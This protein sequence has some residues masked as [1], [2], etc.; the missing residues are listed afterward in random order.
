MS[1]EPIL[2]KVEEVLAAERK[3]FEGLNLDQQ[4]SDDYTALMVATLRNDLSA[5]E[6]LLRLGANPDLEEES[7]Q[8]ALMMAIEEHHYAV[9][10]TL[11]HYADINYENKFGDNALGHARFHRAEYIAD[12]LIHEGAEETGRPTKMERDNQALRQGYLDNTV[13]FASIFPYREAHPL[14]EKMAVLYPPHNCD[15]LR[16]ST[17]GGILFHIQK[18]MT[19][20]LR[21]EISAFQRDHSDA[22][23][24]KFGTS[25]DQ[26]SRLIQMA[27]AL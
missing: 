16:C 2:D 18:N 12:L 22:E 25:A 20:E 1:E 8:T 17:C 19:D 26:L 6:M 24:E 5:V 21:D 15:Q 27:G 4:D 14:F 23:L 3:A 10:R 7:G 13:S 9:V 11:T